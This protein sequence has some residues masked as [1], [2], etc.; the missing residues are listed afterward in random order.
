[1]HTSD[2]SVPIGT[3]VTI[4]GV[5]EYAGCT[6]HIVG[7]TTMRP[8]WPVVALDDGRRVVVHPAHVIAQK[9]PEA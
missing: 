7:V 1:M 5:P 3:P 8:P 4:S 6:G 9:E 2:R